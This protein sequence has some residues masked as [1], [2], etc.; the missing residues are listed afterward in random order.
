MLNYFKKYEEVYKYLDSYISKKIN[1]NIEF[2]YTNKIKLVNKQSQNTSIISGRI[3]KFN[4]EED[5][6][7]LIEK[8]KYIPF[9]DKESICYVYNF[10]EVGFDYKLNIL[11]IKFLT[12]LNKLNVDVEGVCDFPK[13]V[14]ANISKDK[15]NEKIL[16]LKETLN[17][18]N[19][20]YSFDKYSN[21]LHK[22]NKLLLE[23]YKSLNL[24][25]DDYIKIYKTL[26]LIEEN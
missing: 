9:Y 6:I 4:F 3:L 21:I 2:D 20:A 10:N 1:G 15:L 8:M 14:L 24:E 26:S 5:T 22:Y 18:D 7:E 25:D 16:E 23:F 17:I 19:E 11:V 13:F 12:Y